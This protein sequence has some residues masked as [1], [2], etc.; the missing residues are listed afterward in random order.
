MTRLYSYWRSSAAY[1]VR[2]ALNLKNVDYKTVAID[3]TNKQTDDWRIYQETNPQGL[4]PTLA[5]NDDTLTQSTAIIEYLEEKYPTPALLPADPVPRAQVRAMAQL[6]ACDIHPLNNL[7]VLNYLRNELQASDETVNEWYR[8]WIATGFDSLE[9]LVAKSRGDYCFGNSVT[10][11]D[12][13]LI[14]QMYNANRF[15]CELSPYPNLV[16]ITERLNLLEPFINASPENQPDA[17]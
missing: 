13:F 3:L 11:A 2:I 9:Q 6:V 10:V 1:R 5:D 12:V 4:V 7:R 17:R 15:N 14:P 16:E 8:N